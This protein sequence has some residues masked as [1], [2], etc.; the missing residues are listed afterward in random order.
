MIEQKNG[1]DPK[2]QQGRGATPERRNIHGT[3]TDEKRIPHRHL[4]PQ[5]HRVHRQQFADG[6][7]RHHLHRPGGTAGGG[8]HRRRRLH[9]LS[10][11]HQHPSPPVPDLQPQS[12]P[13]AESGAVRLAEGPVRD[14]EESGQPGDLPQLRHRHGG[15]DEKRLH[16]LLRPPLRFPAGAGGGA[17]GRAVRRRGGS[18]HPDV[19]LPGQH[20]PEQEGRRPAAGQCGADRGRDPAG[21][22]ACG[23]D[24]P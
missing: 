13:G 24:L 1:A 4:R 22:S 7:R 19:R 12:A 10:R 8:G 9:R 20:G 15:A 11:P 18:G 5:R 21:L 17:A 6:G 14:L 16:H 3:L 23:G 2:G